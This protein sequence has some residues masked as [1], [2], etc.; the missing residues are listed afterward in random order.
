MS[1]K[2]MR[3]GT[4]I[5]KRRRGRPRTFDPDEALDRMRTV[6]V[7]KGFAGASLDDLAAA[8]GLNRPSLY[9]AFGDKEQLYIAAMRRYGKLTLAGLQSI[10][11]KRGPIARRLLEAYQAAIRLY[12][13]PPHA[14]GCMIIGTAA[15]EAP[16]RPD[17]ADAA[18]EL[19]ADIERE[20]DRAFAGAVAAR[21]IGAKPPPKTRARMAAAV[22]DTLAIRARLRTP[23]AE[24][25][26]FARMMIPVICG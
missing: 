3:I 17:I 1:T 4:K 16:T 11:A 5:E 13:A 20:L 12:T 2:N 25:E 23:A 9:T 7:E 6:F 22:L 10:L 26:S 19:L 8:A 24:L 18:R 15:T 14:P 21:E